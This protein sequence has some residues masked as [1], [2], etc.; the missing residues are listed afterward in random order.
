MP[1]KAIKSVRDIIITQMQKI[2]ND[3][4]QLND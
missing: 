1:P 3:Q 4:K 2:S